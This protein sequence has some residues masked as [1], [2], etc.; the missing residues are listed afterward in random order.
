MSQCSLN[1][2]QLEKNR[3]MIFSTKFVRQ[4]IRKFWLL[5][6]CNIYLPAAAIYQHLPQYIDLVHKKI[7]KCLRNHSINILIHRMAARRHGNKSGE[8]NTQ[9]EV[10]IPIKLETLV[11]LPTFGQPENN[12]PPSSSTLPSCQHLPRPRGQTKSETIRN[13]IVCHI[14]ILD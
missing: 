10:L 6:R 4:S 8:G 2:E 14:Q 3:K 13:N 12:F 9:K 5:L 1:S 11:M 7:Q